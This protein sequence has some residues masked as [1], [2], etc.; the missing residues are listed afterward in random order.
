MHWM[1]EVSKLEISKL[2]FL[3]FHWQTCTF[4]SLSETKSVMDTGALNILT[5][6]SQTLKFSEYKTSYENFVCLCSWLPQNFAFFM[7]NCGVIIIL[8]SLYIIFH[9]VL[10]VD[11]VHIMVAVSGL[12]VDF[13]VSSPQLYGPWCEDCTKCGIYDQ[14]LELLT[15]FFLGSVL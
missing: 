13:V 8:S 1:V 9:S 7:Y 11:H 5:A 15:S 2:H 3:H 10:Q 14:E 6:I 4:I 12:D